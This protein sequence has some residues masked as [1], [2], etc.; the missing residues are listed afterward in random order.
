[1]QRMDGTKFSRH[2]AKALQY[3]PVS[4]VFEPPFGDKRSACGI[5]YVAANLVLQPSH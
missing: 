3:W 5:F 2:P 4:V 1:M